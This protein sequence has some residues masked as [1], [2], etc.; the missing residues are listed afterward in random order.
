MKVA[1]HLPIPKF[2]EL[3]LSGEWKI[4]QLEKLPDLIKGERIDH[5][6]Q[7]NVFKIKNLNGDPKYPLISKV[8]K[9][10]LALSHGN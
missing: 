1:D 2:S 10:T 9:L 7:K 6:W 4:L 3:L 5:Y 8:I